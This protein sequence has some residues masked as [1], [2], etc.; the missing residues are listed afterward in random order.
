MRTAR[1]RA[2]V[3]SRAAPKRSARAPLHCHLHVSGPILKSAPRLRL[4]G[5]Q[6]VFAFGVCMWEVWALRLPW[7]GVGHWEVRWAALAF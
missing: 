1:R 4:C 5:M 7:D 2:S 6:D 3:P